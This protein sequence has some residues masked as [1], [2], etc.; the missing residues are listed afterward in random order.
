MLIFI[1]S[2]NVDEITRA[3]SL[4][5]CDG[6]TTNP[7]LIM[8]QGADH[9]TRISEIC[10]VF[11]GPVLAEPVSSEADAIVAEGRELHAIA[12]NVVV[13]IPIGMPGVEAIHR[14]SSEGIDCAATL[15]FSASQALIAS[16]AGARFICP[17]VG[18]LD[19]VSTDGMEMI[20]QS[21]A[22]YDAYELPTQ[23]IVASVRHPLHLIESG[24]A[25]A[26]GITLPFSVLAKL[27]SHPLTDLGIEQ[28]RKDAQKVGGA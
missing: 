9:H 25:G 26:D 22:L 4:G 7:T 2:A 17:F 10:A 28:F 11:S 1:D 14:L 21:A 5:L 20:R 15:I 3:A 6:V 23:I 18:R 13:K 19:D 8:K 27:L 24:L 12:D 16:K